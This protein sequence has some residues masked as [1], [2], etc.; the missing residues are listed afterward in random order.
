MLC[1]F[2]VA[3]TKNN[4]AIRDSYLLNIACIS[5]LQLTSKRN[6][7]IKTS[8]HAREMG[9]PVCIEIYLCWKIFDQTENRVSLFGFLGCV[10]VCLCD[11]YRNDINQVTAK[12]H[13]ALTRQLSLSQ[14]HKK[15]S[16]AWCFVLIFFCLLWSKNHSMSHEIKKVSQKWCGN[17]SRNFKNQIF[18][19]SFS[20][21]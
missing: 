6:E 15:K 14:S 10:N 8:I 16:S 12:M 11:T 5:S 3:A 4:S 21:Q 17:T 20:K 1:L 7:K 13:I 19:F 2:L 9:F 18:F